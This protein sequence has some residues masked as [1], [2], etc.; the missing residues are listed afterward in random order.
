MTVSTKTSANADGMTMMAFKPAGSTKAVEWS[1]K[2]AKGLTFTPTSVSAYITRFG[3]DSENGVVVTAKLSDGTSVDLGTFTA[4][5][6]N[7]TATTDKYKDHENLTNHFDITLTEEQQAR[8]TSAD[9]FTL[10]CTVGVGSTKNGGFADVHINGL[11]NGTVENVE[12]FTLTTAAS[13]AEGGSASVYPSGDKFDKDTEL[14]VTAE[15]NFGYQFVNWTDAEGK[16]VSKENVYTFTLTEN[17]SLTANFKKVNTY[18][19]NY[20]VEGGANDYMVSL[21][22]APTV[23][24]GKNMY[25][26]GTEVTP[27]SYTHLTLPTI[28]LV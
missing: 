20:E 12:Q 10:N 1:V 22:P 5:R 13:P 26:E 24:E 15:K 18:A 3:T 28:L 14:K 16:E 4:M 19:L 6:D 8:L 7:K 11:L 27:V 2:P 25:E 21:S 17:T 9:G 23:V